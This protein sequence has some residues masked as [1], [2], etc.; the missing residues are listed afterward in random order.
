MAVDERN[1]FREATLRICGSL[2]IE[3]TLWQFLLFIREFIPAE[4]IFLN[5][6]DP[7][8]G[9][10]ETVA[11]ADLRGG[12]TTSI[13]TVIPP[14]TR[15]AFA[16]AI[17]RPD[18]EPYLY[19][20]EH[21]R[22][23]EIARPFSR[24]LGMPDAPALVMRPKLGGKLLGGVVIINE[25][26]TKY[27]PEHVRLMSLLNEPFAIALSNYLRYREVARLKDLL[28]DDNRYLHEE[29][30]GQ[31]GEEIIGANF[32]LKRV[33]ELVRQVAPLSSPVLLLGETGVGKEVIASAIHRWSPRN[34]GPFIKVNCGAIPETLIDS[35]LFGHEKGAFTGALTQNRGRFERAHGGTIF[36]DEIGD[37]PHEAQIR[38]LRVLQEKEIERV[39]GTKPIQVD[40]RVIAAT[41]RDLEA[42][43]DKGRFRQDLYFR[44]RVFPIAIT[45]LRDRLADIPAL[46]QHFMQKKAR[47]MG[48]A[49]IPTLAP[50]AIDHLMNYPWPGNVRELQNA[51]ERAL[52]VSKEQPL[53]FDDLA[54]PA[55][56]SL[57]A[58]LPSDQM[59]H[60]SLSLNLSI[61]RHII[62]VL[63][64]TEGR[65][66][67][68][69]GA[70]RVMGINA[71]TLRKKMRK[72]GV[73]FGRKVVRK[74]DGKGYET[75][76]KNRG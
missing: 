31:V 24:T 61:S 2:K 5:V 45:P 55:K 73:P 4:M 41:H 17:L 16:E 56:R 38:L 44:L 63:E 35:E 70:A 75:G 51:V 23:H 50:N 11:R 21:M 37:L 53:A 66:G 46:V 72:L 54:I 1:F 36:L 7:G 43:L 39:G 18:L 32:G 40:I 59:D 64:M 3:K 6:Y 22:D 33:M 12:Q 8:L 67:G 42:M 48:L 34:K 14:A 60:D 13:N 65:V 49:H 27:S 58:A 26:G 15:S 71:S 28:A 30:R 19:T 47:E 9:M 57:P 76:Q 20:V 10:I 25:Q 29:L 74:S 62:R 69:K 52:I 68:E